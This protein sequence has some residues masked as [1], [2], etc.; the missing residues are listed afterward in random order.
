MGRHLTRLRR[1]ATIGPSLLRNL[2]DRSHPQQAAAIAFLIRV[3]GAAIALLS[4]AALARWM[5]TYEFGIYAYVWTWVVLLGSL[6]D[7]GFATTAQR[8]I[9]E[10][11]EHKA[12]N[13][14]R[15][16]LVGSRW[17]VVAISSLLALG[18]AL[19]IH[20][21]EPWI[22]HFVVLPLYLGCMTLPLYGLTMVQDGIARSYNWINLALMPL[23]IVRPIA[24]IALMAVAHLV[25][26]STSAVT[27]MTAAIVATWAT[28]ILQ[29]LVLDRRL[30][31]R[32]VPGP[33]AYAVRSWLTTSFSVFLVGS[34]YFL[35]TYV[36]VLV[37]EEFRPPNEV[38][39]YFA[40]TKVLALVAFIYFSVWAVAA[41]KFSEFHVAGDRERLIT[42]LTDSIRW[43]FWPSLAATIVLLAFGKPIL[44]LF[45][46]EFLQGYWLLPLLAVGLLARAS[47]GPAE[48]LLN[49]LGEQ[50]VCAY[51]YAGAFS[52]NLAGCLILIPNL[53]M[54]GAA[55][56]TSAAL[57]AESLA[58]FL[59]TKH[60][61]GL[62]VF[63]IGRAPC[64]TV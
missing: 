18:A 11:T 59:V 63:I 62:H 21:V 64:A 14:L 45:G 5:D 60:R 57:I 3:A 27:A 24:I 47:V 50:R 38:A 23:Y 20:L 9:P 26:F 58:L 4:Q 34:F 16:F 32:I 28:A 37:L 51:V 52:L 19:A 31:R 10:Y 55:I 12:L 54:M 35:L 40:A 41:R 6:I 61:L 53:G 7:F 43:T 8:V 13:L 29:L 22:N 1:L 17:L 30:K 42:F 15:G 2:A 56:S 39:I 46:P 44:W 25:G 49:M 48:R 33:K 36:D